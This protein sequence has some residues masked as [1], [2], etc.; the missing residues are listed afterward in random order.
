MIVNADAYGSVEALNAALKGLSTR[1]VTVEIVHS[2]VGTITENDVNLALASKAIVIGF[3]TKPDNKAQALAAQEKVDVRSYSVIYA[4]LD[5]VKLAMAGLLAPIM[6]ESYLGKAEVRAVF[7]VHKLGKI[8]G[9][10]VLDGKIV[11]SAKIRV[12]RGTKV[13]HEGSIA[14][15]KRFKD[16]AKEVTHGYECGIGVEHFEDVEV[17]DILE[18]YELKQ[19]A[20]KL[21]GAIK[22]EP[23]AKATAVE[24]GAHA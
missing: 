5:E 7:P 23:K 15:L 21:D 10:Y 1:M 11:R 20:A 4:M 2:G 24:Q 3:N 19:V 8:A 16:D 12:K 17:G 13:L 14:S 18:C 9:S 22:D 6:E